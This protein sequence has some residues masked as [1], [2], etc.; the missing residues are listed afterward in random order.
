MHLANLELLN[1]HSL[2]TLW[3]AA[4]YYTNPLFLNGISFLTYAFLIYKPLSLEHN[5]GIKQGLGV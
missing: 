2:N 4:F 3:L 5:W 1:L